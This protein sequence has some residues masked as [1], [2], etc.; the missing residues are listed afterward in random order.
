MISKAIS[1]VMFDKNFDCK[2]LF[3]HAASLQFVHPFT[4]EQLHL[5]ADFPKDWLRLFEKFEWNNPLK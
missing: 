5:K 2:N 3:L 4:N 1:Y